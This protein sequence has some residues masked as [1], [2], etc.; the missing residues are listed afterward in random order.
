M[1]I[2]GPAGPAFS[3]SGTGLGLGPL[4]GFGLSS[5]EP[6]WE[7]QVMTQEEG[8]GPFHLGTIWEGVRCGLSV[9]SAG[10]GGGDWKRRPWQP[11]PNVQTEARTVQRQQAAQQQGQ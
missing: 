2:G 6:D 1:A 5:E 4:M 9:K 8:W 7:S 10:K 3:H 11:I